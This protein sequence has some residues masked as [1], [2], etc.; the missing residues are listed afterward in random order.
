MA[1]IDAFDAMRDGQGYKHKMTDDEI[2]QE[3]KDKAGT[4]FDPEL[5]DIF[6]SIKNKILDVK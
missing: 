2:F 1:I 5:A 6:I 4:Q 3:I